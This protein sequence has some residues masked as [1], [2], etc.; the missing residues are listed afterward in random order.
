MNSDKA[1]Q[2]SVFPE[3]L[4]IET[5]KKC[6]SRCVFCTIKQWPKHAPVMHD[7]IYEKNVEEIIKHRQYVKQVCLTGCGEPL[8]DKKIIRR[9]G[10]LKKQ[11]VSKVIIITNASLL[12]EEIASGLLDSGLDELLVTIDGIDPQKYAMLR[13]GLD[14]NIVTANVLRFRQLRNKNNY[15]TSIRMRMEAHPIFSGNDIDAWRNFWKNNLDE[16]DGIYA[17]KMHNWGNQIDKYSVDNPIISP[18]HVLWTTM[19]IL[20]DGQ[21]GL[22]CIDFIPKYVMGNTTSSTI[23]QIWSGNYFQNVRSLHATGQRNT[24]KLCQNCLIWESSEKIT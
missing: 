17:K 12:S 21:V 13:V 16:I 9:I 5:V 24:I 22:C 10:Y 7:D 19:N 20:S 11:G 6:N 23:H 15:S 2:F 4:T 3:F 14:L 18:C 8:L 1:Y